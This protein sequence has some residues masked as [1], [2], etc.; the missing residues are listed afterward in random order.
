[1]ERASCEK[2]KIDRPRSHAYEI[3]LTSAL[4]RTHAYERST[5]AY[6]CARTRTSALHLPILAHAR[7]RAHYIRLYL[8]TT[9]AYTC[10]RTRTSQKIYCE[11]V[12][13]W[14]VIL[15]LIY[16]YINDHSI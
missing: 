15:K 11:T 5:F 6:T 13:I 10:G 3:W 14:S 7:V 8:R 2:F 9:F 1:M 4:R 16:T 12:N